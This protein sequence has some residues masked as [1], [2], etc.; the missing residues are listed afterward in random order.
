MLAKDHVSA[1]AREATGAIGVAGRVRAIDWAR[2][3][4]A[5]DAEGFA[6]A[7]ALLTRR[8]CE[9]LAGLYLRDEIFRSRVVMGRHG[10]GRGE[11][12][13]LAYPLPEIVAELRATLYPHLALVASDGCV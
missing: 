3:F 6:V 12:K 11:Y 8:D 13:Y 4:E 5:L 2:V 9:A 10:F 1:L 7:E